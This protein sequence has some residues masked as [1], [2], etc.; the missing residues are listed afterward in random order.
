MSEMSKYDQLMAWFEKHSRDEY[1]HFERVRLPS[2]RSP[3][4]CA[5]LLLDRLVP[6]AGTEDM[7]SCAEHDEIYLRVDPRELAEVASE[8][9][10]IYLTRCGVSCDGDGLWMFA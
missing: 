7:V 1:G 2:S 10:V 5:F 3:D 8:D 9:D 4:L 6:S